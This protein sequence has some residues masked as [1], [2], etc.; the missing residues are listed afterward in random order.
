VQLVTIYGLISPGSGAVLGPEL[1][2][3]SNQIITRVISYDFIFLQGET[4]STCT[5]PLLLSQI[6]QNIPCPRGKFKQLQTDLGGRSNSTTSKRIMAPLHALLLSAAGGYHQLQTTFRLAWIQEF[7][8]LPGVP[9]E[10]FGQ[11]ASQHRFECYCLKCVDYWSHNPRA[12]YAF[13]LP[14]C[15]TGEVRNSSR[16]SRRQLSECVKC[17]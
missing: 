4:V 7:L 3:V 16:F 9:V 5:P 17:L 13:R 2:V 12:D 10:L 14:V 11:G 6:R 8:L 1:S 15:I